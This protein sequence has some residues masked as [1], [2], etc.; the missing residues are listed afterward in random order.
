GII[1]TLGNL[2][3]VA[4]NLLEDERALRLWGA[5]IAIAGRSGMNLL[6][7]Q[8]EFVG[9]TIAEAVARLDPADVERWQAAGRLLG[10][11]EAIALGREIIAIARSG[12]TDA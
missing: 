6:E 12:H 2:V 1:L 8:G 9:L 5:I 11:D 10:V 7:V 4:V 3:F